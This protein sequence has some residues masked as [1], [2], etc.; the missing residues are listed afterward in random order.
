MTG[1]SVTIVASSLLC[2]ATASLLLQ[3]FLHPGQGYLIHMVINFFN[4]AELLDKLDRRL[5]PDAAHAGDIIRRVAHQGLIVRDMLRADAEFLLDRL[6]IEKH[7][8][9]ESP[10]RFGVKHFNVRGDELHGIGIAGN[11][12]GIDARLAGLLAQSAQDII[13]FIFIN[14]KD[15]DIESSAPAP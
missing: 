1:V 15:G 5:L 4:A 7:G 12:D 14:F 9:A 11:D 3:Y 6:G 13:G 8:I 10:S 2:R